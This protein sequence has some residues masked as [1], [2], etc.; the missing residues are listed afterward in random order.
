MHTGLPTSPLTSPCS[1]S[2]SSTAMTPH[3]RADEE[4]FWEW[5]SV[6]TMSLVSSS[7]SSS[8]SFDKGR[9]HSDLTSPTTSSQASD[10]S[11]SKHDGCNQKDR[12]GSYGKKKGLRL[13]LRSLRRN[14]LHLQS[15]PDSPTDPTTPALSISDFSQDSCPLSPKSAQSHAFEDDLHIGMAF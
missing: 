8:S 4:R 13:E 11:P 2:L 14:Q 10:S 6:S 15:G 1:F 9:T 5:D 3:S 7:S 12:G